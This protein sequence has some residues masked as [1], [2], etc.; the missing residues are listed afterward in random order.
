VLW[1]ARHTVELGKEKGLN[2]PKALALVRHVIRKVAKAHGMSDDQAAAMAD[3]AI[4]QVAEK[5][6]ITPKL[7]GYDVTEESLNQ[8]AAFSV[9]VACAPGFYGS[10]KATVCS[11]S[12]APY[13]LLGCFP[14]VCSTPISMDGYQVTELSRAI[15]QWNVSAAC[16][17]FFAGTPKVTPCSV[18]NTPYGLTGCV[19]KHCSTSKKIKGH[20]YDVT[21]VS[22][23]MRSFEINV[24]CHESFK[25]DPTAHVCKKMNEPYE[26]HG[27]THREYCISPSAQKQV[28]YE[29]N[30]I[31]LEIPGFVVKASCSKNY[32]GEA[33]VE[34]CDDDDGEYVLSGCEP[35]TCASHMASAPTGYTITSENLEV[36]DFQ[37]DVECASGYMGDP[38]ATACS[39]QSGSYSVSGC[40]PK[41]CVAPKS[42]VGYSIVKEASLDMP[43]LD[44]SVECA[45]KYMG[46]PAAA[47]CPDHLGEYVLSGYVTQVE[48][49]QRPTFAVTAKCARLYEGSPVVTACAQHDRV[50]NLSGCKPS[51]CSRPANVKA[52]T[53]TE[54]KSLEMRSF[55]VDV[56]CALNY[57]GTASVTDCSKADEPYT[58]HGCFPQLCTKPSK[59]ATEG[60]VVTEKSLERPSFDVS[61][62]C[63]VDY[64]GSPVVS[65][66]SGHDLPF[67]VSGCKPETCTEPTDAEKEGYSITVASLTRPHFSVEIDCAA[68]YTG[69]PSVTRCTAHGRP[70][71]FGGCHE[72]ECSTAQTS[73]GFA[74]VHESSRRLTSWNVSAKCAAGWYGE[75]VVEPCSEHRKPFTL[76]GCAPMV[77][78]SLKDTPPEGYVV[79]A[80]SSLT[81]HSFGVKA[82]CAPGYHGTAQVAS[83]SSHQT[84]Y[85]LTGCHPIVCASMALAP[86]TGYIVKAETSLEQ[87][88]FGVKTECAAGY[89][90]TPVAK[91][92]KSEGLPYTLE[93]CSVKVCKSRV[94]N[95]PRD[96]VLVKEGSLEVPSFTINAH[97]HPGYMNEST[98][99]KGKISVRPCTKHGEYYKLEGCEHE[100]CESMSKDPPTGYKV[101]AE[102]SLQITTF[103]VD[104]GCD[105]GYTGSPKVG[106]CKNHALPYSFA[107]CRKIMCT[108]PVLPAGHLVVENVKTQ[109]D[110]QVD[111]SCADKYMGTPKTVA[112]QE[113][114][115]PYA[116]DGCVPEVCNAPASTVGYT[117]VEGSLERPSFRVTATCAAGFYG[118]PVV[119]PCM[120]HHESY[121]LSGCQ[122]EP[123]ISPDASDTVA[124]KIK[125]VSLEVPTFNVSATCTDDALGNAT[126][127]VCAS[128]YSKYSVKGCS[129]PFCTKP[130]APQLV[131][132]TVDKETSLKMLKLDVKVSCAEN[133][134]G[135]ASVKTCPGH[136]TAY[137]VDGCVPFKCTSA[138]RSSEDGL[139]VFEKSLQKLDFEV[140]A[141]CEDGFGGKPEVKICEAHN[142]SYTIGG[143]YVITESNLHRAPNMFSVTAKCAAGYFGT[144]KVSVCKGPNLP[145]AIEGCEP[146]ECKSPRNLTSSGYM[147]FENSKQLPDFNVKAECLDKF[148]GTPK[149]TPCESHEEVY[150]LTG[151]EPAKCVMPSKEELQAY[152]L[153]VKSLERPFFS[154]V[155]RCKYRPNGKVTEGKVTA[156]SNHLEPFKVEGCFLQC[157]S[158]SLGVEQGYIVHEKNLLMPDFDVEVSCAPDY[159]GKPVVSA[160][161]KPLT[162]YSVSGCRP[163]KCIAP[164]AEAKKDYVVKETSLEKP[165]FGV[166]ATCLKGGMAGEVVPCIFDGEPYTLK[167]CDEASCES[168]HRTQETGYTVY[169]KD[170]HFRSF[171]VSADCSA[172]FMG[173]GVVHRCTQPGEAFTL[174]GCEPKTCKAPIG[175]E[176]TDYDLTESSL[177]IPTFKV[178]VRCK[179]GG[180]GTAKVCADHDHAYTLKGCAPP[181]CATPT[182]TEGYVVT[183]NSRLIREFQVSAKCAA[184]Y[185]GKPVA[186]ECIEHDR[187]YGLAGCVPVKCTTPDADSLVNYLV[188]ETSLELPSYDVT[189]RCADVGTPA[190]SIACKKDGQPYAL[191][192]CKQHCT[193]PDVIPKGHV[194]TESNLLI[195]V[196]DV[197]VECGQGYTGVP[198]VTQ[199]TLAGEPYS[200]SGCVPQKCA[201]P[202][203]EISHKYE[204]KVNSLERPS[205]DVE[206]QCKGGQTSTPKAS[207]CDGDGKPF[208]LEG[209]MGLQCTSP[210]GGVSDGYVVY[211]GSIMSNSF[212]VQASCAKGY[213]GHAKASA[214]TVDEGPYTLSG[215]KPKTCKAP[216]YIHQEHVQYEVTERSLEMPSF[217][218]GV[219]C[220]GEKAGI[221][222]A[223][224]CEEDG[225]PYR[226]EGCK[227]LECLSPKAKKDDGYV[228]YEGSRQTNHFEVTA[229]CAQGYKGHAKVEMCA[230]DQ[231]PYILSG[232]EPMKC[233]E[234]RE[235]EMTSYDLSVHSLELPSFSVSARCKTHQ[236]KGEVVR[237]VPC[238]DDG[239]EFTLE[240][241]VPGQCTSPSNA[242]SG[243]YVVYEAS[244]I[245]N[246]F[247]VTAKCAAGYK[248][249]A[250]V[251]VCKDVDEPYSLGGCE[252]EKCTEPTARDMEGYDLTVFSL[253][254]PSFSVGLKCTSGIGHGKAKECTKDG[255]PYTLEGCYIGECASPREDLGHGYIVYEQSKMRHNF[256]VTAEC[257]KGYRGFAKVTE[258]SKADEPYN[259]TGCVPETCVEPSVEDSANYDYSIFSL[260]RPSFSVT[261]RCKH[262]FLNATASECAYDGGPFVLEGCK[263]ACASPK[264]AADDGYTVVEK[265]LVM[266]EFTVDALCMPDYKGTA[267]VAKCPS[268]RQPYVLS[269]C[270]PKKCVLPSAEDRAAYA[271]TIYSTDAPSFSVTARCKNGVGTGKAKKCS[272][273]GQAFILEGCPS[274]CTSPKKTADEGYVVFER[275]MLRKQFDVGAICADGYKGNAT[276]TKCKT[277]NE[278]YSVGGCEPEKCIEASSTEKANYNI[279]TYSL[280]RPSFSVTA[281][282]K[283][284]KGTGK[285]IPCSGDNM[286]YKLEGCG[287]IS[288]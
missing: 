150:N 280:E 73:K 148:L 143:C 49:L 283:N 77:C 81:V 250:S 69:T 173:L 238:K 215:C 257:A 242:A 13:T 188:T 155:P 263:D 187:P 266:D 68:G 138:A 80:E 14:I 222:K 56:K 108:S 3:M 18:H 204:I 133:Y 126:T 288:G 168:P 198:I 232:C 279:V 91:A 86:P 214:C 211:E 247:D 275:S 245:V 62:T 176:K 60:Y 4:D 45:D 193:K 181:V 225:Q 174:T 152:D 191:T 202:P 12:G 101:F 132:Y 226:L 268:A 151:C 178:G 235:V 119:A 70:Y 123:C 50:F 125:E 15:Y 221:P 90:G 267:K 243:G 29:I 286:P 32:V 83:C 153:E 89:Y 82:S 10:P 185:I 141:D 195:S 6:C 217:S 139:I 47:A 103:Q 105:E 43:T 146:V 33:L 207:A 200:V 228:V 87:L 16:D 253:E 75:V 182:E 66:C 231:T 124:Y 2:E 171:K 255:E 233:V 65:A 112:C 177:D 104:I 206:V 23:S 262:G 194:V 276:V 254:R 28:G 120:A 169:E 25:G 278:P 246:S 128:K 93:G 61:A 37:V 282:C 170:R 236:K 98:V 64:M 259:L 149:V 167:G 196:F 248:G 270:E 53:I 165:T 203:D 216:T 142:T 42:K 79:N 186:T 92:C 159:V 109:L 129:I 218:V 172:G 189:A 9:K 20:G 111:A 52:Y 118:T 36:P 97:C 197:K 140:H 179:Y 5:I 210:K 72:I 201:I 240:G 183:E 163:M 251:A 199:C 31:D 145:Y 269:G 127:H 19:E 131:G 85:T 96:I 40:E 271:L 264:R 116:L 11:I 34:E 244:M 76:S 252:P 55:N 156:C 8:T 260:K 134:T 26:L 261:A 27:C 117:V 58:L 38:G 192:G 272:E 46:T 166:S 51:V 130:A 67:T 136:G 41:K 234:P 1:A 219:R 209:C 213:T 162:T 190:K 237:A 107:G 158:T 59:G 258:C 7:E 208:G 154:V 35:M 281:R 106:V 84:A 164:T 223:I 285:A 147:V 230:E 74:I 175:I 78:T 241:C 273:D 249:K 212:N 161:S 220:K 137:S 229:R 21:E 157:N 180:T 224:Q 274:L 115:K 22:T 277:A 287:A 94:G 17:D 30:E 144:P 100:V 63:A 205:F 71:T 102:E 284:G 44:V 57:T 110:F 24:K 99:P 160:C 121:K 135:A 239:D 122:P 227:P 113:D 256:E 54:E 39:T 48:S 114:G 184:G 265:K 95:V 88:S